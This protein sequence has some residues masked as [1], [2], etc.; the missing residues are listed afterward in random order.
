MYPKLSLSFFLFLAIVF[1]CLEL[2]T[3]MK[4]LKDD[5]KFK[6]CSQRFSC[7]GVRNVG[8]PFWGGVRTQDCG[9]PEFKLECNKDI[10]PEIEIMLVKFAVLDIYERDPIFTVVALDMLDDGCPGRVANTTIGNSPFECASTNAKLTYMYNCTPG[11]PNWVPAEFR[12]TGDEPVYGGYY[13]VRQSNLLEGFQPC[14]SRINIPLL[15]KNHLDLWFLPPKE[16]LKR[17]FGLRYKDDAQEDCLKCVESDGQ[18]GYDTTSKE[19]LCFMS[20]GMYSCFS[21][22][23]IHDFICIRKLLL[24]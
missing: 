20:S 23:H 7:G 2:S 1:A 14:Q 9:R 5:S 22:K 11:I 16:A 3:P 19:F 18:C 24:E 10:N 15:Q 17:G 6:A 8:Y 13:D 21:C 4:F 12:C